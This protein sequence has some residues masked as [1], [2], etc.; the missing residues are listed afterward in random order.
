MAGQSNELGN[1]LYCNLQQFCR[2]QQQRNT[3]ARELCWMFKRGVI[4]Q[5]YPPGSFREEG[6]CKYVW[7]NAA[8]R[9]MAV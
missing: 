1:A 3:S 8:A 2:Q 4:L 6:C 9:D 7:H 5:N